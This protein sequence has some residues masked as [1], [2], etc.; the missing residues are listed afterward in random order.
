VK[1]AKKSLNTVTHMAQMATTTK[2]TIHLLQ[3]E[4]HLRA[5]YNFMIV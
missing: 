1:L 5:L 4:S 2:L 3:F